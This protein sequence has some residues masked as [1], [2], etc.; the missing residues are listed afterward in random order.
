MRFAGAPPPPTSVTSGTPRLRGV[1]S[2]KVGGGGRPPAR[3]A[4]GSA[5]NLRSTTASL[6]RRGT[7]PGFWVAPAQSP[8]PRMH[9]RVA[10]SASLSS[11]YIQAATPSGWPRGCA[12]TSPSVEAKPSMLSTEPD[13]QPR[14]GL[15]AAWHPRGLEPQSAERILR[16]SNDEICRR[17]ADAETITAGTPCLPTVPTFLIS[18]AVGRPP[19]RSAGGAAA[20]LRWAVE[21]TF[22]CPPRIEVHA[23]QYP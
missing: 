6:E 8:C 19:A 15:G 9:S 22:S 2:Y 5:A 17:P 12:C 23:E 16:S 13:P 11:T 18:A 20:N 7:R 14:A 3:S 1:P 10:S 4:G 21:A